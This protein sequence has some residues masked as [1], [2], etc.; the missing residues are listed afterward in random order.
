MSVRSV[1]RE[2]ALDLLDTEPNVTVEQVV[3]CAYRRHG[4][5]FAEESERL[6]LASARTEVARLMRDMIDDDDD[7]QQLPGFGLPSAICVQSPNGT[8]YVRADKA[9]WPELQAG[10]RVRSDNVEAATRKLDRYDDA[11]AELEPFMAGDDEI[12]VGKAVAMM[13]E[14]AS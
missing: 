14:V 2:C 13:A 11:L 4:E 9:T 1:L 3:N 12:T 8:Y 7:E 10:R 6:V 5:T